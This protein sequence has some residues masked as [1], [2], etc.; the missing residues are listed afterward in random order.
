MFVRYQVLC[1]QSAHSRVSVERKLT[2]VFDSASQASGFDCKARTTN[3][4]FQCGSA[5]ICVNKVKAKKIIPRS[6][7][8]LLLWLIVCV[9]CFMGDEMNTGRVCGSRRSH[10]DSLLTQVEAEHWVLSA[11]FHYTSMP[12]VRF[13]RGEGIVILIEKLFHES[14]IICTLKQCWKI[15]VLNYPRIS[16]IESNTQSKRSTQKW[17]SPL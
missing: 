1:Q 15:M 7:G 3:V 12:L 4:K 17:S 6:N 14:T 5:H 13:Q 10:Q 8:W 9:D 2:N 11:I 16:R